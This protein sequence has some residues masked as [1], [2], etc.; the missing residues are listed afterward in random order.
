M[1]MTANF[2]GLGNAATPLGIRAMNELQRLN[3][4]SGTASDAMCMFAVLNTAAVQLIPTTI[5]AIRASTGSANPSEVIGSIWPVS[6]C[7]VICAILSAKLF[8]QVGGRK[9]R[10]KWSL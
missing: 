3:R 6:M 1:N 4:N 10:Q 5:I 7:T 9:R 2:L 8:S